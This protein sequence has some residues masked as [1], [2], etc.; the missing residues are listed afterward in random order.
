MTILNSHSQPQ[1]ALHEK[2]FITNWYSNATG[3]AAA[4]SVVTSSTLSSTVAALGKYYHYGWTPE[5]TVDASGKGTVVK[6]YAM[7]RFS[8][9][10]A[11]VV[12]D[13]KTVYFGDDSTNAA[14]F[15]FIADKAQD[16]SAGTLYAAKMYVCE[17]KFCAPR[18]RRH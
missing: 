10:L 3:A 14:F 2:T 4:P 8:H 1:Y 7:G 5:V 18:K 9:E 16:L 11:H 13:N 15:M 6:H 12:A 17:Y